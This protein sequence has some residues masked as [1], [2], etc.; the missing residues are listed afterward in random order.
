MLS[1]ILATLTRVSANDYLAVRA[2]LAVSHLPVESDEIAWTEPA[3][4]CL[5]CKGSG[6]VPSRHG[7]GMGVCN[8]C[9]GSGEKKAVQVTAIV[10]L[11]ELVKSLKKETGELSD[12]RW[13]EWAALPAETRDAACVAAF[14]AH[15]D[16]GESVRKALRM[17]GRLTPGQVIAL[18]QSKAP[19]GQNTAAPV[20]AP[21]TAGRQPLKG[22]IVSI[23]EQAGEYGVQLKMLL[24][25]ESGAR[26]FGTI[27]A[28]LADKVKPGDAVSLVATV[29]PKESDFGFFSRPTVA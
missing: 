1:Q 19:K 14:E 2:M 28:Q 25:L 22:T 18:M 12:T 4:T 7:F 9:H 3:R 10:A 17:R 29:Q 13:A 23:K 26:V 27:P 6:R 24:K 20:T 8:A 15:G 21:L 11:R 16:F 5:G